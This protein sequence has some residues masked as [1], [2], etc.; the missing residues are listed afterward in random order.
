MF[1]K[2]TPPEY[3]QSGG[4][5]IVACNPLLQP[6]VVSGLAFRDWGI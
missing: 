2:K 1:K 3:G 6:T 5:M 4:P